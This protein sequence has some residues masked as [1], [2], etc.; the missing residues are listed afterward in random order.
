MIQ[1]P[2]PAPSPLR[3]STAPPCPSSPW[4]SRTSSATT[5]TGRSR[6]GNAPRFFTHPPSPSPLPPTSMAAPRPSP[7]SCSAH[8]LRRFPPTPSPLSLPLPPLPLRSNARQLLL[9]RGLMPMLSA[10]AV[11]GSKSNDSMLDDAVHLASQQGL[12]AAHDHV[13]CVQV[14]GGRRGSLLPLGRIRWPHL[15][16]TSPHLLAAGHT[17]GPR[18]SLPLLS[19]VM[20][21]LITLAILRHVHQVIPH[22]PSSMHDHITH[23][24]VRI[25][26]PYFHTN[27]I[28][29]HST[30]PYSCSASRESSASKCSALTVWATASRS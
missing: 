5:S 23:H 19:D 3:P 28:L 1:A 21:M 30:L 9:T 16:Q 2:S 13:V 15:G 11:G 20:P 29:P 8:S 24:T 4:S 27:P 7:S 10:P 14:R 12:V 22:T 26:C 17:A 25:L 6:A 18:P